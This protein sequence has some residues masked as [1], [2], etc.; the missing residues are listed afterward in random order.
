MRRFPL[1]VPT[2]LDHRLQL[3]QRRVNERWL[4]L[5]LYQ[6][7]HGEQAFAFR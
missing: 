4:G 5:D 1:P 7:V 6:G 2:I 3:K